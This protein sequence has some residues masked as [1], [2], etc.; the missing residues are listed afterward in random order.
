MV[1]KKWPPISPETKVQTTTPDL[2][3]RK[4]WT[5]EAWAKR[6]WG[7]KGTIKKHHDSHGLCYEVLHEDGTVGYYNPNELKVLE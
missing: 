5:K 7:V 1:T 3:Q 2:S 4:E 6:K